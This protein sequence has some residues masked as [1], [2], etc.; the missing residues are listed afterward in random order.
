[1]LLFLVGFFVLLAGAD[2]YSAYQLIRVHK[3]GVRAAFLP[4][5]ASLQYVV[6]EAKAGWEEG[7]RRL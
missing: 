5:A 2:A 4:G 7:M 1:M 6:H 3:A